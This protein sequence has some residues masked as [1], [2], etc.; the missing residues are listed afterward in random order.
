M[1]KNA[2]L[3]VHIN[4]QDW[5]ITN[6][7]RVFQ[8]SQNIVYYCASKKTHFLY[9]VFNGQ[10][11][12]CSGKIQTTRLLPQ[13]HV[14]VIQRDDFSLADVPIVN[15]YKSGIV[16]LPCVVGDR[17]MFVHSSERELEIIVTTAD[18]S[19]NPCSFCVTV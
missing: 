19:V 14:S 3:T 18:T 5:P 8:T 17:H 7:A 1:T 6:N 2:W 4:G 15:T 10:H 9:F 12:V 11:T 13:M 16:G